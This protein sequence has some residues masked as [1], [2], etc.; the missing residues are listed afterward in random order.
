MEVFMEIL[1][2]IVTIIVGV[3][4]SSIFVGWI[5]APEIG[6]ILSVATMGTFILWEIR[7]LRKK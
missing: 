5:N 2:A 1:A 4:G 6:V 7:H 3:A